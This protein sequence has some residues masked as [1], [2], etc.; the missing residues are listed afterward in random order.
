MK[1]IQGSVG[2]NYPEQSIKTVKSKNGRNLKF[3][4]QKATE[5]SDRFDKMLFY[6]IENEEEFSL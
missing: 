3:N 5:F 4:D 6:I 1:Y 2:L